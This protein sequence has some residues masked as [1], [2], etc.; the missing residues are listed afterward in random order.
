M[1]V[2]EANPTVLN[3]ALPTHFVSALA[4]VPLGI[5]PEQWIAR[6]ERELLSWCDRVRHLTVDDGWLSRTGLRLKKGDGTIRNSA[7]GYLLARAGC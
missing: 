6:D 1:G 7:C 2:A 4:L 3:I 5:L